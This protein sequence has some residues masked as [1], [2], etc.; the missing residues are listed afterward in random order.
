MTIERIKVSMKG[1]NVTQS[2]CFANVLLNSMGGRQVV[3]P[4]DTYKH[5]VAVVGF[6]TSN[7][8]SLGHLLLLQNPTSNMG[9]F[10]IKLL[11]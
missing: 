7:I 3:L 4:P 1:A 2:Q 8:Y 6:D 5:L 10:S 9:G 11:L